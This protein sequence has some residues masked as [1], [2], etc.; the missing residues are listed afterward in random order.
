MQKSHQIA[1]QYRSSH[2]KQ[3]KGIV[4]T[5][6]KN[7]IK[8]KISRLTKRLLIIKIIGYQLCV[9]V[10][11]SQLKTF[12]PPKLLRYLFLPDSQE[13]NFS[14]HI[15]CLS[16]N[17]LKYHMPTHKNKNYFYV[18]FS[19]QNETVRYFRFKFFTSLLTR[20]NLCTPVY[21]FYS[22]CTKIQ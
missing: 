2:F 20:R 5:N 15:S 16:Y 1:I 17:L 3:R 10:R 11:V 22:S 12:V 9:R 7:K 4:R 6:I 8:I 13:S 21:C 18:Y 19:N 14:T